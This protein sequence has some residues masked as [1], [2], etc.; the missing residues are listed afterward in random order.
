MRGRS[1]SLFTI[2]AELTPLVAGVIVVAF[3]PLAGR[4]PI[5]W[6]LVTLAT[7]AVGFALYVSAKL[8]MLKTA[9]WWSFGPGALPENLRRRY[10]AGYAFMGV[11]LLMT[12]ALS[13]ADHAL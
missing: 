12:L 13:A 8:P 6:A 10:W 7:Y 11:G 9:R 1:S 2:V 3:I 5:A 4:E